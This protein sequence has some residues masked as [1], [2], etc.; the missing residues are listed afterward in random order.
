MFTLSQAIAKPEKI[1]LADF[2][3]RG[4]VA[5]EV[6]INAEYQ[7]SSDHV[8][9]GNHSLNVTY[10]VKSEW[11]GIWLKL[12]VNDWTPFSYFKMDVFNPLER[13]IKVEFTFSDNKTHD[14]SSHCH[15]YVYLE[16]GEN[17]V[18][19]DLSSIKRIK[20]ETKEDKYLNLKNVTSVSFKPTYPF[21]YEEPTQNA[22]ID[23]IRLETKEYAQKTEKE[24]FSIIEKKKELANIAYKELISLIGQA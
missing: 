14:W 23:Y 22:Y 5:N 8:T 17:T 13:K 11:P 10:T 18:R 21:P 6:T 24:A 12:K 9:S 2:E 20:S 4:D 1:I 7:L 16:S 3:S 19:L 15:V